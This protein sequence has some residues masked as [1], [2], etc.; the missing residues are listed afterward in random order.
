MPNDQ[1]VGDMI[2]SSAA[3]CALLL[4]AMLDNGSGLAADSA[5]GRALAGGA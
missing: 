3:L 4:L 2:K 1:E 5:H